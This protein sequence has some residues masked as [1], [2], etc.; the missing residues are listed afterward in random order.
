MSGIIRFGTF[1]C[2]AGYNDYKMMASAN[3]EESA[4]L[5]KKINEANPQN[6]AQLF[7]IMSSIQDRIEG[8]VAE[9]LA[10]QLD[11]ICLQELKNTQRVFYKT[12]LEQGFSFYRLE[13]VKGHEREIPLENAVAIRNGFFEKVT[14]TS[15]ASSSVD[16]EYST[17][18]KISFEKRFFGYGRQIASV[19]ATIFGNLTLSFTSIHSWGFQLYGKDQ[20]RP[21]PL[22]EDDVRRHEQALVY[23]REATKNAARQKANLF[24][25]IA[26]DLNN[27]LGQYD[28][29]FEHMVRAGY[30]THKPDQ[31]TNVN[32]GELEFKHR[33]IDYIFTGSSGF[34][35]RVIT[36]IT[37]LFVSTPFV[38]YSKPQVLEGFDFTVET[39]CSDHKPVGMTINIQYKKS[40][41]AR[42]WERFFGRKEN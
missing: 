3:P 35:T 12:L 39:N 29:A 9:K 6:E 31:P 30:T 33:T 41:I 18:D 5:L 16:T 26:G 7:E 32:S 20:E 17:G 22:P 37:S 38:T 19:T 15:V 23:H 4:K 36:K 40:A 11:V 34:L 2:G 1:N 10:G 14:N 13:K 28:G 42:L 25:V 27:S 24:N 21:D 8:V